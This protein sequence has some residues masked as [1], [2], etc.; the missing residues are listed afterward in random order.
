MAKAEKEKPEKAKPEKAKPERAKPEKVKAKKTE[1]KAA[2]AEAPEND[3][4]D[5]VEVP[6]PRLR[7][8]YKKEVVKDLM[9]RFEYTSSMQVPRLERIV[10]N[11]GLGAAVGNPKIIDNAVEELKAITGQK[12]VVTRAKKAIANFK[13]REGLPIG[14]KVTLRRERMWE[15]MDRLVTLALPRVR[16]FRGTSPRA[17]DG[18]GNYTL[19]LKE[20]IVFPEINFDS[21][22]SV[23]GMN[24]TFVTTARTNE[25]AKELL[26][27][28]GMPFRS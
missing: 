9:K 8:R 19:G 22:D 28:L 12:P 20:Q 1:A 16:D 7:D 15:F 18:A 5:D 4:G 26:A 2:E 27:R 24:I 10:I 3:A 25:E 17:F 23:K 13:L 11:M 14:V 21:V 6:E